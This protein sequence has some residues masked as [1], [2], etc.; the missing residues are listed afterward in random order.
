MGDGHEN[1]VSESCEGED[2]AGMGVTS[3]CVHGE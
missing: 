3:T 1:L 2:G